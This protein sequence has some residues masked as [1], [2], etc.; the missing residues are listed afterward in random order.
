[1]R[2]LTLTL[3]R[4]PYAYLPASFHLSSRPAELKSYHAPP[5]H[6]TYPAR[7]VPEGAPSSSEPE[8]PEALQF[9]N[10]KPS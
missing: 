6:P 2:I 7:S 3:A 1:M 9:T 10:P 8:L 4:S 5:S